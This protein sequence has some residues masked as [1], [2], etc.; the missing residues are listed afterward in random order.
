M[1]LGWWW[2]QPTLGFNGIEANNTR[3]EPWLTNTNGDLTNRK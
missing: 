1:K 2:F 3:G